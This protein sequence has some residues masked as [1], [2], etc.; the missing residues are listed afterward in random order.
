MFITNKK[1]VSILKYLTLFENLIEHICTIFL[2][3]KISAICVICVLLHT[4]H[5]D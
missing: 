1:S 5:T 3:A 4:D 2:S